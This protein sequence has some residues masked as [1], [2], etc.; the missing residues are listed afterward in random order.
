MRPLALTTLLAALAACNATTYALTSAGLAPSPTGTTWGPPVA[1]ADVAVLLNRA[2]DGQYDLLGLI[3]SPIPTFSTG[4]SGA[5]Y[6]ALVAEAARRGCRTLMVD[7]RTLLLGG[8][9]DG[10]TAGV[11]VATN[12]PG[13]PDAIVFLGLRG[14]CVKAR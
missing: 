13:A 2:P 5:R 7:T 9:D 14:A 8:V 4:D 3:D 1:A 11:L 12:R 10:K 6:R